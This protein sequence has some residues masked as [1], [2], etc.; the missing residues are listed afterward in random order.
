MKKV[1]SLSMIFFVCALFSITTFAYTF[2]SPDLHKMNGGVNNR[3][4]TLPINSIYVYDGIEVNYGKNI[5]D[6]VSM[7]NCINYS[8]DVNFIKTTDHSISQV[9]FY[10][11]VYGSVGWDGLCEYWLEYGNDPLTTINQNWDYCKCKMN[12]SYQQYYTD[13]N[14]VKVAAHE[15]GHALGLGHSYPNTIMYY[16]TTTDRSSTLSDDDILGIQCLY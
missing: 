3:Y 10:V 1:L 13:T 15:M 12:C 7:W 4:Y 5:D 6:A 16:A 9:D 8:P 14:R 11:Y 2:I